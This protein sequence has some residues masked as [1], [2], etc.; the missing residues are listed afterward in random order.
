[1]QRGLNHFCRLLV[2]AATVCVI[3]CGGQPFDYN[4]GTEIP[5]GPG[6]FSGEDG[7]FSVYQSPSTP[8][9]D[10]DGEDTEKETAAKTNT[11]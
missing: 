8:K 1:M 11:P 5:E 6:L 3:G 4:P 10:V 2:A 9:A 7:E